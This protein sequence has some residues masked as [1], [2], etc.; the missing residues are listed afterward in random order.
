LPDYEAFKEDADTQIR[1]YKSS[2]ISKGLADEQ[3]QMLVDKAV[4]D[5][6][7]FELADAEYRHAET[8]HTRSLDEINRKVAAANERYT[9]A[10]NQMN[11][12]LQVTV[13]KGD[14]MKWIIPDT[15]KPGFLNYLRNS[16][17]YDKETEKFLIVQPVGKE[18]LARQ[19]EAMYLIY[20]KGDLSS[21]IKRKAATANAQRLG[22]VV[23]K[24]K[25]VPLK[26]KTADDGKVHSVPLG[27]L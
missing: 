25:G 9:T 24:S 18:E 13:E 26:G 27:E 11:A 15:E 2:L 4:K 21:I 10:V 5:G 1:V 19:I 14:G 12:T 22:Q 7:I 23:D 8:E 16:V 17:E 20:K 3:A 6:K